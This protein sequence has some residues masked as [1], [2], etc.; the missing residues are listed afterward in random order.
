MHFRLRIGSF[1]FYV[2]LRREYRA[3]GINSRLIGSNEHILLFD[4]DSV[5]EEEVIRELQDVQAKFDLPDIYVLETGAPEHYHAYCFAKLS[6][7]LVCTILA[8][9]PSVDRV[10]FALGVLRG[11]WTL[12][13]S[14]KKGRDFKLVKVLFGY[15]P[16]EVSPED[17]ETVCEYFTTK[18]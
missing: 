7:A 4:F 8:N 14:K 18:G 12:R 6:R 10:F 2:A 13:I 11:Y 3:E 16:E 15:R 17:L 9:T 1:N 5:P